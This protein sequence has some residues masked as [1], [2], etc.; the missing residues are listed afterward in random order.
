MLML[1][2]VSPNGGEDEFWNTNLP[3]LAL[4]K[5]KTCEI[6]TERF[7][8]IV[9]DEAQDLLSYRYLDIIDNSLKGGIK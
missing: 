2:D 7:D 3:Q 5:L 9:I 8:V 1:A 6:D 4:K